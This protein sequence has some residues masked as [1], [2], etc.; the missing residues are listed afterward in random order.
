MS[1][2]SE[3]YVGAQASVPDFSPTYSRR[4]I[5]LPTFPCPAVASLAEDGSQLR[6]LL[7]QIQQALHGSSLLQLPE[8]DQRIGPYH[9]DAA[10]RARG[11]SQV[12]TQL[13]GMCSVSWGCRGASQ[14][15]CRQ[16]VRKNVLCKF[17][18]NPTMCGYR[19]S[20]LS[21]TSFTCL[22]ACQRPC[23]ISAAGRPAAV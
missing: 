22:S 12:Y 11:L 4:P 6:R 18:P 23:P 13:Q 17:V 15:A 21:L 3:L 19:P 10:E 7:G 9:Y 2:M 8:Q 14:A 16:C 1:W 20:L 5:L